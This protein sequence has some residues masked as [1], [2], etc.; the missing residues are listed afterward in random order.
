MDSILYIKSSFKCYTMVLRKNEEIIFGANYSFTTY[1]HKSKSEELQ[2][3]SLANTKQ[4]IET[5]KNNDINS[6][7][8]E[9]NGPLAISPLNIEVL[10]AQGIDITYIKDKTPIPHNGCRPQKREKIKKF[11]STIN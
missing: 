1:T 10:N 9:F 11:K 5:C 6:F 3:S 4:L 8:I 7:A 2:K